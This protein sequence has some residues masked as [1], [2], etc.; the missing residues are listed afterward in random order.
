M[1]QYEINKGIGRDIE[2]KGLK[3]QY[4]FIFAIG[5]ACVIFLYLVMYLIGF[6]H[7]ACMASAGIVA[8]VMLYGTYY[9]NNKYGPKGLGKMFVGRIIPRRITSRI[10]F[11]KLLK[12]IGDGK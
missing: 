5:I 11:H 6:G 4:L 10:P 9:L 2:L 3:A 8:L 7:I 1:A 12:S